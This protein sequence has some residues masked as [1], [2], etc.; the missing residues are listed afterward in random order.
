MRRQLSGRMVR[1]HYNAP[2]AQL[3]V[4]G[5]LYFEAPPYVCYL[6]LMI[7]VRFCEYNI[8]LIFSE[9]RIK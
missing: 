4:K 7:N 1:S 6:Y 3:S 2:Q 5:E 8:S 9:H